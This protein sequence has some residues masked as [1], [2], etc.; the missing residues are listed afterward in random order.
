[1][2]FLI[3]VNQAWVRLQVHNA[4]SVCQALLLMRQ[5]PKFL[6]CEFL[7]NIISNPFRAS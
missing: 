4:L 2:G 5:I 7:L 3:P 1:M 6:L